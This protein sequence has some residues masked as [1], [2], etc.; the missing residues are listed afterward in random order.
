MEE[1]VIVVL[2]QHQGDQAVV[3]QVILLKLEMQYQEQLILEEVVEEQELELVDQEVQES[4]LLD[5]LLIIN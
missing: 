2:Q 4:L 3:E 1:E 5:H